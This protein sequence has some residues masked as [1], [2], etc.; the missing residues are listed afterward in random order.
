MTRKKVNLILWFG[1]KSICAEL[2][3]FWK[4]QSQFEILPKQIHEM[5]SNLSLFDPFLELSQTISR[6]TRKKEKKKTRTTKKT[7]ETITKKLQ[8][9]GHAS[10]SGLERS[11]LILLFRALLST[12]INSQ[13]VFEI[14]KLQNNIHWLQV[15]YK[16]KSILCIK[17]KIEM[18]WKCVLPALVGQSSL[19]SRAP[20]VQ[21]CW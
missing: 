1:I 21:W 7:N 17:K 19:H 20:E 6:R 16:Y 5:R 4:C 8:L 3:N 14:D 15:I 13:M 10:Y 12:T 9:P 18:N 11:N 2:H